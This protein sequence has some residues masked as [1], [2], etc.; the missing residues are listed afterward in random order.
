MAH[1]PNVP[2]RSCR[3]ARLELE[4]LWQRRVHLILDVKVARA[5]QKKAAQAKE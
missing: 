4:K 1:T 5:H 3:A 2:P